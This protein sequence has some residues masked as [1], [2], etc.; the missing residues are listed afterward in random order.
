M[1]CWFRNRN[2]DEPWVKGHIVTA[3]LFVSLMPDNGVA[4][5]GIEI[6]RHTVEFSSSA[7]VIWGT[8]H[9]PSYRKVPDEMIYRSVSY[10]IRFTKPKGK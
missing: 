1:R 4:T 8:I 5:D 7:V 3:G 2:G 9:L 10:E 6:G